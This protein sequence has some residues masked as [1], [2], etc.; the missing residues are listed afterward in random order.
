MT[1]KLTLTQTLLVWCLLAKQGVAKQADIVPA[2]K[3]ADRKALEAA[4]LVTVTK[5]SRSLWLKLEDRGWAWAAAHLLDPLPPAQH[6][7]QDMSIRLHDYLAKSGVTMAEFIGQAPEPDFLAS[8]T[9]KPPKKSPKAPKAATVRKQLE[10]A[11]LKVTGGKKNE[12]ALLSK[13]RAELTDLDRDT[14]DAALGRILKGDKKATLMRIDNPRAISAA[15]AE[16][17][18]SPGGE[19]F[20][21]LWITS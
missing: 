1:D 19:P 5:V 20:H 9:S 4:K 3:A 16:A 8:P 18:Y 21:V 7:L 2:P 13:I 6:A 12:S 10:Q 17:A 15:E 11:Y 14:V